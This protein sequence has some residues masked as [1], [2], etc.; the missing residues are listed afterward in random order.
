MHGDTAADVADAGLMRRY[1]SNRDDA[2]PFSIVV[3]VFKAPFA[4]RKSRF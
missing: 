1:G 3:S 2:R 4:A